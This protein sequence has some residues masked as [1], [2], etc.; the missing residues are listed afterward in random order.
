M[1]ERH[2]LI[3]YLA[4][5]FSIVILA[6]SAAAVCIWMPAD[7]EVGIARILGALAFISAAITGLIGVIGT[8]KASPEKRVTQNIE[9]GAS[10]TGQ[11]DRVS[12]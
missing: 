4:T 3:A 6:L 11:A 8:F 12:Q 2:N 1:G 5:L 7:T 9:A 10:A